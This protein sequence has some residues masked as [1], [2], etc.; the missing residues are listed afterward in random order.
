V[1]IVTFPVRVPDAAGENV[2]NTLQEA[3][4]TRSVDPQL[5]V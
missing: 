5:V 1:P 4:R 3:S 2:R